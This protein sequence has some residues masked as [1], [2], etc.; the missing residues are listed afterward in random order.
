MTRIVLAALFMAF[1]PLATAVAEEKPKVKADG[2]LRD[3]LQLMR[4]PSIQA[5]L[6][7]TPEQKP[8]LDQLLTEVRRRRQEIISPL[9]EMPRRSL[10]VEAARR[11]GAELE[12]DTVKFDQ[13]LK[14]LLAI[15]QLTRFAEIR[16]Q[17]QGPSA[18]LDG[19]TQL[20]LRL[21]AD[22]I[23]EMTRI[24]ERAASLQSALVR[25]RR[26]EERAGRHDEKTWAEK[27]EAAKREAREQLPNVLNDAQ[28]AKFQMMLGTPVD[29]DKLVNEAV[30]LRSRPV[31]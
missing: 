23:A 18:L 2:L 15:D 10:D 6:A 20:E 13:E 26:I 21:S 11:I 30:E 16:L 8:R 9:R 25:Q 5:E 14:E 28:K 19:D 31:Q 24:K 3:S 1:I 29:V 12:A 4:L 7:I 17:L 22:Q 27:L